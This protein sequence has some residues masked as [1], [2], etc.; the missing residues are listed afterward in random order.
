MET[1]RRA[2]DAALQNPDHAALFLDFDGTLVEI[3]ATPE[4]AAA[5]AA[6]ARVLERASVA[7]S[8]A[9]A[10]VSGRRIDD[11]DRRLA[12][13]RAVAA[14]VHGAEMRFHPAEPAET[15]ARLEARVRDDVARLTGSDPRLLIEDK[16]HAI[17]VHY[18]RAE[19]LGPELERRLGHY[20]RTAD[21]L[22]VQRG[23]KVFELLGDAVSKG[24]AVRRF[25][26]RA[27]FAG[28]RPIMIGDD[29]TDLSAFDACAEFGGVGLRVAG[30]FFHA[31]EADFASPEQVRRWLGA[32]SLTT[33]EVRR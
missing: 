13:F 23:R 25:M 20:V 16:G 1:A 22:R 21:G 2:L 28:R 32:F 30:E 15:G 7:L 18:R 17:A 31:G 12:P 19:H 5:P 9:L 14:G 4:E 29:R 33:P 3:A 26:R 6:L 8:G 27:P 11:L 10:L 24:E